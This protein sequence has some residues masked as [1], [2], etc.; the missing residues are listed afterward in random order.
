[1]SV[2]ITCQI[3]LL[4]IQITYA[5]TYVDMM[6]QQPIRLGAFKCYAMQWGG[7]DITFQENITKVYGSTVLALRVGGC[8]GWVSNF[9]KKHSLPGGGCAGWVSNFP[10][11]TLIT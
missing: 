3:S 6:M 8:A 9:P 4:S 7:G 10:K 2:I 1:M 5:T 11:K